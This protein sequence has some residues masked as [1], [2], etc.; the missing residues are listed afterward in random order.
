MT[1]II[2][3]FP[4]TRRGPFITDA[5]IDA[6]NDATEAIRA[7]QDIVEEMPDERPRAPV[8]PL[9]CQGVGTFGGIVAD[10]FRQS[11]QAL[12][13]DLLGSGIFDLALPRRESGPFKAREDLAFGKPVDFFPVGPNLIEE[14][15]KK[16]GEASWRQLTNGL[17]ITEGS[18]AGH[19]ARGNPG[20]ARLASIARH[21][22]FVNWA[23]GPLL[24]FAPQ[25]R[26]E[27]GLERWRSVERLS[28]KVID[29]TCAGTSG[30]V[31]NAHVLEAVAIKRQ[32]AESI[33][34]PLEQF[35]FLLG[36]GLWGRGTPAQVHDRIPENEDEF[37]ARL[38]LAM[39]TNE[40]T[41]GLESVR[42]T[43]SL[44][45]WGNVIVANPNVF[46]P[47]TQ[48]ISEDL[49]LEVAA[50]AAISSAIAF[51]SGAMNRAQDVEAN[52]GVRGY[53]RTLRFVGHGLSRAALADALASQRA[54]RV[55]QVLLDR[56]SGGRAA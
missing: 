2:E 56:I 36:G 35:I 53:M 26:N 30:A 23:I 46:D 1:P 55:R 38:R 5:D 18:L 11:Y 41:I 19:G 7:L 48:S 44:V 27:P 4:R 37:L 51:A 21:D 28:S 34:L 42:F 40:V 47:V 12:G 16:I 13:F 3:T 25:P 45:D 8:V 6:R 20:L 32:F 24:A 33:G 31:G 39:T 17:T 22:D 52:A 10:F 9:V 43:T 50:E 14:A 15:R 49:R 54:V 29:I